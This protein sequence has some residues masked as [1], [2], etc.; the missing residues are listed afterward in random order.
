MKKNINILMFFVFI[1]LGFII[2][3]NAANINDLSSGDIVIGNTR[4]KSGTW[5]S[6]SRAAKA[7]ALYTNNTGNTDL[8]TYLYI[9][10]VVIYVYDDT[11]ENYKLLNSNEIVNLEIEMNIYYENNVPLVN[12]YES[13]V[14]YEYDEET[15]E[16]MINAFNM[17]FEF[18]DFLPE[19]GEIMVD[20]P[21]V[22]LDYTNQ[23]ITCPYDKT[24][25]FQVVRDNEGMDY[26][27]YCGLDE[28]DFIFADD[29]RMESIQVDN[30]EVSNI[31]NENQSKIS[32]E[33]QE[34]QSILKI[35]DKLGN[36]T[37]NP[38]NF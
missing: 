31:Q 18:Y 25:E 29:A 24:F 32:F 17:V 9:N 4:F 2:N 10:P 3:V 27:G 11:I 38:Y 30:I 12:T 35:N 28:F 7:G 22:E 20:D 23:T 26:I 6:A 15:G 19:L 36:V 14:E 5:V 33:N 8:N 13:Y 21:E 37:I 1:F 16:E 34:Y